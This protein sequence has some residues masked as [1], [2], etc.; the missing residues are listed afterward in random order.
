MLYLHGELS[1]QYNC[2]NSSLGITKNVYPILDELKIWAIVNKIYQADNTVQWTRKD[3]TACY[4]MTG[5]YSILYIK[6]G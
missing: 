3:E 2:L 1:F 5:I 6:I 4:K